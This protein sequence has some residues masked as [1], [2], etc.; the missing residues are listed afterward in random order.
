MFKW[1]GV[2]YDVARTVSLEKTGVDMDFAVDHQPRL[3]I[4]D[5][6]PLEW[7]PRHI[8]SSYIQTLKRIL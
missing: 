2:Y 3:D 1:I 7:D 6:Y 5:N 4:F 8:L